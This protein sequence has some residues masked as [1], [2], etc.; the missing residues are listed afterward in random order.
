VCRD[1][2]VT[3]SSKQVFLIR[4]PL[5]NYYLINISKMKIFLSYFLPI[6]ERVCLSVTKKMERNTITL[7][8]Y[9]ARVLV[10][11]KQ[12]VSRLELDLYVH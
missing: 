9:V 6:Y 3:Q 2:V 4:A 8:R 10:S 11:T 5:C 12:N 7:L 1:E